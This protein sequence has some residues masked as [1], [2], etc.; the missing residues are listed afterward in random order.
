VELSLSNIPSYATADDIK[1]LVGVKHVIGAVTDINFITNECTG[2][3]S[4]KF[5]LGDGETKEQ[6]I[7]RLEHSQVNAENPIRPGGLNN[8]YTEIS[9]V[10]WNDHHN[11]V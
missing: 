11:Q 2:T 3:G 4:V 1:K 7:S 5:R 9:H 8:N 10:N 6:V